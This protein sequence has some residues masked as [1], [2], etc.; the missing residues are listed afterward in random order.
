MAG[1]DSRRRKASDA[2]N[3]AAPVVI[4]VD[5]QLGENIGTAA[6]AM[7]NCGL[8][9][10]RLVRPRDGWPNDAAVA[11]ASGA[12]TVLQGAALFDDTAAAIADL[13][14][15]YAATARPRDMVKPVLT[16]RAMAAEVRTA[17]ARGERCGVLFGPERTGLD[18]DDV[19]LADAVLEVPLNP[20]FTSLNLAQAVLIVGYEW[21]QAGGDA[22]GR[23]LRHNA[24]PTASKAELLNFFQRLE[25]ELDVCGFLQP[26]E[27]RPAMVR[28]IRN[29]FDRA[30]LTEQEVRTLH[31]IVSG[32]VGGPRR[33]S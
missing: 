17:A 28:A 32:L 27:K 33:R 7:L 13:Q 22:P 11:A 19:A 16:P 24:S 5:P 25:H 23:V 10:L 21:Y 2:A 3:G 31:G 15:V 18:N 8:G 9:E 1:T 4:L 20:G 26:A 29:L 30:E 6:R 14:R 12:D